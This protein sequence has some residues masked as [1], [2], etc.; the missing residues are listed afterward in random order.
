MQPVN[1]TKACPHNPAVSCNNCRLSGICLPL[2]LESDEI[3]R[4]DNIVQRGRPLQ[5]SHYLFREGDVF[6]SVYAVRS[7]A[8]KTYSITDAGDEQVTG[9]YFPGE[10]VGLDGIGQNRYASSAVALEVSAICEIPFAQIEDLSGQ[11]PN[12]QR[13]FFKLR[14]CR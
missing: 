3:V 6:T 4:L 5:K 12:L 2:A 9:F 7:G 1:A 8:V 11:L 13:H 14:D 10:V